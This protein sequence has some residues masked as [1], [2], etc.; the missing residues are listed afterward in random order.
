MGFASALQLLLIAFKLLTII[1][2]SWAVVLIP[3]WIGIVIS[4]YILIG[5]GVAIYFSD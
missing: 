1:T 5:L 2:W 3:L 4:F